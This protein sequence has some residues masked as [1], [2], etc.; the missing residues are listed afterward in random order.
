MLGE[1]MPQPTQLALFITNDRAISWQDG[2]Y[3]N[4]ISISHVPFDQ[5]LQFFQGGF[6]TSVF[7]EDLIAMLLEFGDF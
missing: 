4:P 3:R 2:A 5:P 7:L 1:L 6:A